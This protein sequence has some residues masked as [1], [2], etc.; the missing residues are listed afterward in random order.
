MIV[1][2]TP[3]LAPVLVAWIVALVVSAA[4]IVACIDPREIKGLIAFVQAARDGLA[5]SLRSVASRVRVIRV[6]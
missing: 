5:M 2:L 6:T 4:A 1:D 3:Q